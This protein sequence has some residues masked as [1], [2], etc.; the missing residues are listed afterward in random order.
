M[1]ITCFLNISNVRLVLSSSLCYAPVESR[2]SLSPRQHA[3]ELGNAVL[4]EPL[5]F[6]KPTTSYVKEGSPIVVSASGPQHWTSEEV[7]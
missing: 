6:L 2:D 3:A 7:A 1:K 4:E 5:L